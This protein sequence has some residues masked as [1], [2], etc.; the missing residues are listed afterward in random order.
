MDDRPTP[1]DSQ[2]PGGFP[3]STGPT[4][5][6][7][8]GLPSAHVSTTMASPGPV[9]QQVRQPSYFG[10]PPVRSSEAPSSGST[11][12]AVDDKVTQKHTAGQT[13]KDSDG[14][15]LS[16]LSSSDDESQHEAFNNTSTSQSRPSL[17]HQKSIKTEDDLF[18]VL[19]RRRTN[20]S[21]VTAQQ[22]E[23]EN[24]EIEKLLSR[25]FGKARQEHSEEEKT[26]HSGVIFRNLTVKGV[27]LGAML[28]PTVGDIFLGLPRT[29]KNLLT[30][31]PKAASSKPPVRELLSDFNGC[32]RPGELLLVL[33]RP[34]SGC[35]TFLKT[36]CNQRSGFEA[37]EGDVSYG[38]TDAERM[39]K[40]Y[41][42]EVIYNPEDDLHYATLSVRRTLRFALQTRTPGKESRLEGESRTDY[43]NEFLRVVTKLFWI[44]HTLGTKVGDEFVRGVSGGERKRVSIAEAMITRASVQGWDNSS[45]GLDASTALE[46]VQSI[47]AMTNMAH[48]STAVS[49]YQAGES[50]YELSDKVLLIDG[51]QCLYY[52]PSENAKQYFLNLGFV[53]PERWTTADFLT[54]VSDPHERSVKEGWENRIPRS[55]EDFAS[56]YRHSEAAKR[57][58]ADIEEFE[59]HLEE[60]R[61]I[62]EENRSKK[63]KKK[64]Y[65]IPFHKQVVACTKRQFLVMTGDR[66]SLFGKWGGLVFQ[67]LIVGSLFFQL[68]NTAAGA[69]PR[70]GTL[71]FLLLFNALLALA[72]MTAAFQSKPILLKHKSF[73]FYRPAAYAIA[74]TVVDVPL[75]FIQVL[76]FNI[77][78]YWMAALGATASQFFISCLILW[79]VTMVT[80]AFFRAISAWCPT[81][82][83]A[84]RFTGVAIQILIVYT[85]YLIPPS[86]MRPWFAWLR[87]LNWIQ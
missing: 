60:Q 36:F 48:T 2:I 46:Y 64:N 33:G 84:T 32:V 44:E 45:R 40:D 81:L 35:T 77:I 56:A 9:V 63:N 73:S 83:D 21:G 19:S 11:L 71:F 58:M 22:T 20:A 79:Q 31:G 18:R 87:W 37:V 17:A 43:V 61:Q 53:C 68:P 38:G 42:G 6:S 51:G 52:G 27:G 66:A 10:M 7:Q 54:S 30:K 39:N 69:F 75:V 78:I 13:R 59:S 26:R 50:L 14:S 34:G 80:Y 76:L 25:M 5:A 4:P 85:G 3:E 67:G 8:S 49:L 41:R 65:T 70:G 86:S 15:S 57:N 55:P 29:I 74:Q 82:D 62:R 72:E 12:P 23:E 47:R 16:S 24:E 28:Q 1:R